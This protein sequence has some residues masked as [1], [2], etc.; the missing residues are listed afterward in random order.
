MAVERFDVP[1]PRELAN[2]LRRTVLSGVES[3]A[4]N[5]L[6]VRKNT[7]VFWDEYLA[8]RCGQLPLR[9]HDPN[10]R[11]GTLELRVRNDGDEIVLVTA[12]S[13]RGDAFSPM[14][15]ETPLVYLSPHSELDLTAHVQT[16]VG[17]DHAR[18]C[19]ALAS[20]SRRDDGG[21]RLAIETHTSASPRGVLLEAV[22]VLRAELDGLFAPE[23]ARR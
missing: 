23:Q 22:R 20:L 19:P 5:T 13:L 21:A 11:E 3:P 1:G 8:H 14:H 2:A 15:P 10:V 16:K 9:T 12:S 4:V 7:T 17:R 6:T 18:F